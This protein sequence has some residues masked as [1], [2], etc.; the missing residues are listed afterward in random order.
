MGSFLLQIIITKHLLLYYCFL[1]TKDN[2]TGVKQAVNIMYEN[3]S[4]LNNS[5][6][7]NSKN[8][9]KFCDLN[10]SNKQDFLTSNTI[11]EVISQL[12]N[13]YSE[14]W[15]SKINSSTRLEFFTRIKQSYEQDPFLNEM[16]KYD[17]KRNYCKSRTSNQ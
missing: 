5:Y 8:I 9:L 10:C 17:V 2:D 1:N 11:R 13:K 14:Y 4:I 16:K 15:K 6:I 12:Q 7:S 3:A